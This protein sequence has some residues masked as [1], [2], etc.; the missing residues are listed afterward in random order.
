M[1]SLS[2]FRPALPHHLKAPEVPERP[3]KDAEV[4]CHLSLLCF[5]AQAPHV[6]PRIVLILEDLGLERLLHDL[7]V[8][9]GQNLTIKWSVHTL[10]IDQTFTTAPMPPK[11]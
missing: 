2:P 11:G 6:A 4:S 10:G 9:R 7:D 8:Y 3:S 1:A 5:P